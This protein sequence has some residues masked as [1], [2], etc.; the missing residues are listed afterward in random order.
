[1]EL[2][3]ILFPLLF[4]AGAVVGAIFALA[5]KGTM[6]TKAHDT[7]MSVGMSIGMCFGAALG[8]VWSLSTQEELGTSIGICIPLGMCIGMGVGAMIPKSGGDDQK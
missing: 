3:K 6:E 7:W 4:S 8:V 2:L 5:S 1:M